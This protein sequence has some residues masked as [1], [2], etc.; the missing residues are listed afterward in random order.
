MT[1]HTTSRT[2]WHT[3]ALCAQRGVDPDL[4]F[5]DNGFRVPDE[6]RQLC[7]RC[8]VR[9][10]CFEEGQAHDDRYGVRAG[11]TRMGAAP[12][13]AFKSV[14]RCGVRTPRASGICAGCAPDGRLARELAR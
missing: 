10:R 11:I 5:P 14:C 1:A 6:A 8:P 13:S 2:T 3:Q 12:T 9:A 4:F 7:L